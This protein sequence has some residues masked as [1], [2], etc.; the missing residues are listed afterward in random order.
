MALTPV[1]VEGSGKDGVTAVLALDGDELPAELLATTEKVYA[2]PLVNPLTVHDVEAVV[3]VKL[4]G[5]EVTV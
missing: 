3:H 4:P 1:G 5:E 2:V